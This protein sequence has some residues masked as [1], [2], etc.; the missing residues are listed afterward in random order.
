MLGVRKTSLEA[1]R[2]IF[3]NFYASFNK[4]DDALQFALVGAFDPG[5]LTQPP[6][7]VPSRSL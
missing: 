6:S 2:S 7:T 3:V 5:R 1:W 4:F